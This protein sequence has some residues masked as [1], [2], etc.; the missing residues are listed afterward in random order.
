MAISHRKITEASGANRRS[1]PDSLPVERPIWCELHDED[2]RT[3]IAKLIGGETVSDATMCELP[4]GAVAT[5]SATSLPSPPHV[6][7]VSSVR[8]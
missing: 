8:P 3:W 6:V 5:P 2:F 7:S 4:S 1:I